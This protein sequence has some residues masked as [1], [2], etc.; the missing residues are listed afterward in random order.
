MKKLNQFLLFASLVFLPIAN[1]QNVQFTKDNFPDKAGLKEA[2]SNIM[3]GDE[4]YDKGPFYYKKAL[5]SYLKANQ[6]NPNNSE[7][8][9]KIG[10]CFL[11]TEDKLQSIP[12]LEKAISL[13]P[14]EVDPIANLY[15]GQAY[16][17][18]MQWEKALAKYNKYNS[19]ALKSGDKTLM[20]N[21]RRQMANCETGK[22]LVKKPVNVK[23]ENLGN[24][25]NSEYNDYCSVITADESQIFFTARKPDSYGGKID[26]VTNEN[27]ED[28]Y[29]SERRADGTWSEAKNLPKPVNSENHDAVGGLSADGQKMIIYLGQK[30]SGDLFESVLDGDRWSAP[31]SIG[32]N[33][34]TKDYQESSACYTPDGKGLFFVSDR[35]GGLGE[36]DI[37][38]SKQGETGEWGIPKNLGNV[39]NTPFFEESVYMHPDGKTLYFSSEGHNSMGGYDV[40]K[41]TY[42]ESNDTWST[43]EN[44]GYPVNTVD[45][46]VFFVLSASGRHGYYTSINLKERK[47]RDLYL[48]T[49]LDAE[50][51][52]L[53]STE[54]ELISETEENGGAK[55]AMT[56]ENG[57]LTLLKGVIRDAETKKPLESEIE[58]VDNEL[59]KVIASFKSNS[60]TGKYLV[61]LPAGK[62]YGIAVKK[63]NYLFHSE[64]FDIADKAAF[65]EVTK[66][67]DLKFVAVGKK[68]VLKNIFFDTDKATLRP[69]STAEL[70]RLI[71]LMN[72]NPTLKIE[73]GGHTDSQGS[74][75]HNKGLSER[76][77]KAVVDYLI[78]AGIP[79]ARLKSAGYGE[80]KPIASNEDEVGRQMN[81]RT[82][83]EILEL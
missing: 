20:L 81:R 33:I 47:Q 41:S 43:P 21:V 18:D 46:D 11:N 9:L 7:L 40:F 80:A 49:F 59:N 44:L 73:L 39:I 38:F 26:P 61:S 45:N 66:D 37:Y 2:M 72:E 53:L 16:H 19:Y 23:I 68:I 28:I 71:G 30:N 1:A 14:D 3:A 4:A 62:N 55:A 69:A 8:N 27:F 36:R 50:K 35:P 57:K 77:A 67:V 42:N 51:E 13:N 83:F 12:F 74:D 24:N 76:R 63:D 78:N 48:I 82:E 64:N 15:L 25:V 10:D 31:E 29:V 34:N 75:E 54:D 60:A 65:Q 79:S 56:G 70:N 17:L 22:E 52:M 5:S 6:F 32:K 58:I